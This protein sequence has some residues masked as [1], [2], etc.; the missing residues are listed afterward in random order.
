[1]SETHH[2]RWWDLSKKRGTLKNEIFLCTHGWKKDRVSSE[3]LEKMNIELN[4]I[5]IEL[6]YIESK[7]DTKS[8]IFIY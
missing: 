7:R 6:K 4:L 2:L 5:D 3:D 8:G 1:M